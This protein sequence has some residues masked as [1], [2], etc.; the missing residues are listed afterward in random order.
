MDEQS[1]DNVEVLSV[2]IGSDKY[3]QTVKDIHE[4]YKKIKETETEAFSVIKELYEYSKEKCE[5]SYCLLV[6]LNGNFHGLVCIFYD[7]NV[8]GNNNIIIQSIVKSPK[9]KNSKVSLN[10]ILIPY[11]IKTINPEYIFTNPYVKQAETL[12]K[13]YQFKYVIDNKEL[14]KK[15]PLPSEEGMPPVIKIGNREFTLEMYHK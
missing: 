4:G 15:Y 2:E 7:K 13:H 11:I 3:L 6:Y 8:L 12:Y 5:T 10:S 14:L 1:V 9:Y